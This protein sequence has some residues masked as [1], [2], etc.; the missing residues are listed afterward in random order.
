MKRNSLYASFLVLT[1]ILTTSFFSSCTLS[2]NPVSGREGSNVN[3]NFQCKTAKKQPVD[4]R[5]FDTESEDSALQRG[6]DD[7]E[8]KRNQYNSGKKNR[9]CKSVKKEK[10]LDDENKS[11]KDKS[12]S[13]IDRSRSRDK[14]SSSASNPHGSLKKSKADDIQGNEKRQKP[15]LNIYK[16]HQEILANKETPQRQ[17]SGGVSIKTENGKVVSRKYEYAPGSQKPISKFE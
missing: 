2:M 1:T 5:P 15:K 17:R 6:S 10:T 3:Q 7:D 13:N 16:Q 8:D 4:D 11:S 9:E 12:K 14:L